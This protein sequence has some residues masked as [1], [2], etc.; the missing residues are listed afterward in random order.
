MNKTDT[1]TK[2][3]FDWKLL[4]IVWGFSLMAWFLVLPFTIAV[5]GDAITENGSLS[6][7]ILSTFISN[8]VIL[9]IASLVGL[10]T[11]RKTGL[12]LPFVEGWL[13][14][15]PV[16]DQLKRAILTALVAG[17]MV[18]L[19]LIVIDV[20]V[21]TPYL[22]AATGVRDAN[23]LNPDLKRAS[24]EYG[25]LAAISAGI[26][27]EV[28]FRLLGVSVIAWLGGLIFKDAEG[29]P[30]SFVLWLAILVMGVLFGLAHLQ[31]PAMMGW[32]LSSAAI[33]RALVLNSIGGLVYG[34]MYWKR[35]LESA[36]LTHFSTDLVLHVLVP[37]V[38]MLL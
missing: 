21:F 5:L 22:E 4:L 1:E 30:K 38:L 19:L 36:M 32:E 12:G 14:K 15:N 31:T 25:F 2:R 34:W 9:G 26:T 7:F 6:S 37:V 27:E 24:P 23:M 10:F 17:V 13:G 33:N 18:S 20:V 28:V 8:L 11:A 16:R 29:H 3:P 35:G